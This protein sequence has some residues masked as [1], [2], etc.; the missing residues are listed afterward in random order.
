MAEILAIFQKEKKG[1]VLVYKKKKMVGILSNRDLLLRVA[2][3]N[4]DL[5][6]LKVEDVMTRNPGWVHP[7]DPIAFAV[8]KMSVGG[9]RHVPVL[10]ADGTTRPFS[11]SSSRDVLRYLSGLKESC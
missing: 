2:E 8:N 3:T 10:N 7:E 9:Y 1:C 6:K 11:H 5:D 4:R